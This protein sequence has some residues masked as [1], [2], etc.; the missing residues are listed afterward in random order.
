MADCCIK[1]HVNVPGSIWCAECSSLIAGTLIGDY[2]ILSYLGQGSTSVV[3]LAGQR[4]LN[5][6]KVVIKV[7]SSSLSQAYTSVFRQEAELLAALT[8]PYILPIY[9]YGAIEEFG[10]GFV[11]Y[12]PYLVLPYAEQGSLE[13][14][15]LQRGRRP[16]PLTRLVSLVEEVADGLEYAH[17]R[18]VLHRDIKPANLLLVGSHVVLA[19]FGVASWIDSEKSHLNAPWAGSPAY[20]APE[21][22][23]LRPGRYSD[24]Y[25]LAVTC[26]RLLTGEYPWSSEA[27]SIQQWGHLH[28]HIAP[29]TLRECCLDAPP[30][31][32]LVLMRALAKDPHERYAT[33]KEFAADL[34]AAAQESTLPLD[35]RSVPVVQES[36]SPGPQT[37]GKDPMLAALR[38]APR[39]LQTQGK[40]Q[41][42]L[43]QR[44]ATA[45]PV[46][47]PV[48]QLS[49]LPTPALPLASLSQSH[50]KGKEDVTTEPIG[51]EQQ[52]RRAGR[53]L[54]GAFILNLSVCLIVAL[55]A[56]L[57]FGGVTPATG[58]LLA[59]WPSVFIGLFLALFFSRVIL[60]TF[61]WAI[62]WGMLFGIVD[63]LLSALVCYAWTALLLTIPHWGHDWLSAGDG[64]TIFLGEASK[65]AKNALML[66]L[67]SLWIAVPSGVIIALL[68]LKSK[69]TNSS[70]R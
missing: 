53:W 1:Q 36:R 45:R 62:L 47:T 24:Q 21:V 23:G 52:P 63:T 16:W 19:D 22:W 61:I 44:V 65:L 7:L 8:H 31:V 57:M 58:L 14:I 50:Q 34:H 4:S 68:N 48:T 64:L 33:V 30:E 17:S 9:A 37:T 59:V 32:N 12:K 60:L 38:P 43:G 46:M 13:D 29:R 49:P 70:S 69:N 42:H 54:G 26:Y 67:L 55:W 41:Q 11:S 5:S 35:N 15:F 25:A 18:G 66:T 10:A 6:R 39:E 28:R 20:M 3:Y 2:T 51:G 27:T 40:T 56:A